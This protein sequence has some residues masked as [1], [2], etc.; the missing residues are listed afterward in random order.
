M[1]DNNCWH[2]L[3]KIAEMCIRDTF[4]QH[5]QGIYPFQSGIKSVGILITSKDHE[6]VSTVLKP[7]YDASN[8]FAVVRASNKLR[9]N[10]NRHGRTVCQIACGSIGTIAEY[11]NSIQNSRFLF[12]GY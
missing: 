5:D 12:W 9:G 3:C 7:L 8:N 11:T 2:F 6:T 4:P 10:A 1:P